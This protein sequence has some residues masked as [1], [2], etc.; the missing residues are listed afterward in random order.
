L[1]TARYAARAPISLSGLHYDRENQA[2]AYCYTFAYD[3]REHI[4]ELSPFELI[5]RLTT[6]IPGRYE[7]LI[8]YY[9]IYSSRSQGVRRAR[10]A[11]VDGGEIDPRA[12]PFEEQ[13]A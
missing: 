1:T 3:K 7:R 6:H 9:G 8:R 5:A 4:E 13:G 2:V 10:G 11:G 12:G